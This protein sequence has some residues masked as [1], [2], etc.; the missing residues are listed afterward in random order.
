MRV[1]ATLTHTIPSL[2]ARV[3]SGST[4]L[5]EVRR[6]MANGRHEP[7]DHQVMSP[8]TFRRA[9]AAAHQEPHPSGRRLTFLHVPDGEDPAID[10]GTPRDGAALPGGTYRVPNGDRWLWVFATTLDPETAFELG[11]PIVDEMI[12]DLDV[13]SLGLRPDS[14][15]GVTLAYAEASMDASVDHQ[16][17]AV[18][19][20]QRLMACWTAEEM[21]A[22]IGLGAHQRHPL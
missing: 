14:A 22:S 2:T 7:V 9:V 15:T 11:R 16:V 20:L 17:G 6:P 10:I 3:R 12:D 1:A 18:D 19:L 13:V 5:L 21:I 8:C 4:V